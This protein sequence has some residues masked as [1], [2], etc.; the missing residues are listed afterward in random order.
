MT[1]CTALPE[2][3]VDSVP[4][5]VY[6]PGRAVYAHGDRMSPCVKLTRARGTHDERGA[7]DGREPAACI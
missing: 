7:T 1:C 4:L 3:H 5:P 2:P 6:H